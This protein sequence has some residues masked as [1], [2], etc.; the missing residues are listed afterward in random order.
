MKQPAHRIVNMRNDD[1]L[2]ACAFL[3]AS[4]VSS[5]NY[6]VKSGKGIS[7][8]RELLLHYPA[9]DHLDFCREMGTSWAGKLKKTYFRGAGGK[10]T[11]PEK[12]SYPVSLYM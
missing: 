3:D 8:K 5:C 1:E 12:A 11:P 10:N 9:W 7:V 4:R 2:P 6:F